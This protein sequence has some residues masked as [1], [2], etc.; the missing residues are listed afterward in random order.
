[1]LYPDED[2]FIPL[3]IP[4]IIYYK[5]VLGFTGPIKGVH[6][7]F[8]HRYGGKGRDTSKKDKVCLVLGKEK[9]KY[10]WTGGKVDKWQDGDNISRTART[11]YREL[12]E[13]FGSAPT[14]AFLASIIGA[15]KAS[16]SLIFVVNVTGISTSKL[17]DM[18]KK[19][20][21]SLPS[22]FRE[23]ESFAHIE[24]SAP[25]NCSQYVLGYINQVK[26]I[27]NKS[28]HPHIPYAKAFIAFKY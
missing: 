22:C 15:I 4:I 27:Y 6:F 12:C 25:T 9:G 13:E 1:M 28:S 2:A 23:I 17:N 10:K 8:V 11:F 24:I 20:P 18:I 26:E 7:A 14:K 16:D 5:N 21:S 3:L 19:K